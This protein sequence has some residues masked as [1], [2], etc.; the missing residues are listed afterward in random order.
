MKKR[1]PAQSDGLRPALSAEAIE[2]Y[3]RQ[4]LLPEIGGAG[5]AR[6]CGARVCIEG[7]G[8]VAQTA[9]TYLLASGVNLHED[10][11]RSVA[12]RDTGR[13]A[14]D[15]FVGSLLAASIMKMILGIN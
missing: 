11:V 15:F 13:P 1:R 7:E 12:E 2:A 9:R 5:Q 14:D 10:G 4:L 8:V 6:L 3:S